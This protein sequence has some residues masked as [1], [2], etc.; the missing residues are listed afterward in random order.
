MN[1]GVAKLGPTWAL[2]RASAHLVLASEIDDDHM[3]N[4]YSI[5]YSQWRNWPNHQPLWPTIRFVQTIGWLAMA[6][7]SLTGHKDC[8]YK[9]QQKYIWLSNYFHA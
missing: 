7:H 1:S 4:L 9:R 8:R 2:A 3:I 6:G 5:H